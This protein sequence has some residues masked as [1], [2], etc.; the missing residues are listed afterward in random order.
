VQALFNLARR[1][2]LL[3]FCAAL[4]WPLAAPA[5]E[6]G[7]LLAVQQRKFRLTHELTLSGMF[8]P[9]DA[10][11]KGFAPELSYAFHLDDAWSWEVLRGGYL[12]QVDT[13]LRTQL[14][15]DFGVVPTAF[16]PLQYYLTSSLIWSPLYGKFAL[17][18]AKLVHAEAFFTL[19]G[20]LGHFSGSDAA[21]GSA[22][23]TTG[24]G[25]Y[26]SG[27]EVGLGLRIYL[28]QL[29]SVRFDARDALFIHKK[30][31][32]TGL[33]INQVVFLSLGLSFSLGGAE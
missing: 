27:P 18:N 7:S 15:R 6:A 31:G 23:T 25:S 8:E 10:F 26:Q 30:S 17:R 19:G 5:Q 4:L 29:L 13:G 21:S 16:Q 28:S 24:S 20:A 3:S 32:G 14:E 11:N 12:A 22:S 2:A 1:A 33:P 9:Q